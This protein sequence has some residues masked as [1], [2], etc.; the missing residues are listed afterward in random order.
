MWVRRETGVRMSA[1]ATHA[2]NAPLAAPKPNPASTSQRKAWAH[3][4]TPTGD[5]YPGIVYAESMDVTA[6]LTGGT[7]LNQLV[8]YTFW[9]VE[10]MNITAGFVPAGSALTLVLVTYTFWPAEQM[11]I[12]AGFVPA[13]SLLTLVLVTY[14]NWPAEQMNITASLTG[15]SLT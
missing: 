4:P 9:P 10:Q 13:G 15:G 5:L 14:S 8:T 7:L 6:S 2:T 11:N 1:T 3:M 12:T